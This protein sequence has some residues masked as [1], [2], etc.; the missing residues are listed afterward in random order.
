MAAL[1]DPPRYVMDPQAVLDFAFDWSGWLA[2]A[3]TIIAQT[4]V[5]TA[6]LTVAT[7]TQSTGVVTAW[8]SAGTVDTTVTVTCHITTSAGRQD[9]RSI[10]VTV[11]NR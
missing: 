10:Y 7:V 9:D 8:L 4:V 5:A 2:G 11:L 1:S 3:E 6:G